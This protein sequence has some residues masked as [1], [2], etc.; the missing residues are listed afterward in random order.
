MRTVNEALN[1]S[2]DTIGHRSVSLRKR[3]FR[4]CAAFLLIFPNPLQDS[5]S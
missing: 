5:L 1:R 2:R 4:F 3:C